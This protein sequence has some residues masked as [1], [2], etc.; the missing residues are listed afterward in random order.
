MPRLRGLLN[1]FINR[2]TRE[3]ARH[4]RAL[5]DL[6]YLSKLIED[7]FARYRLQKD[8]SS[9]KTVFENMGQIRLDT[10]DLAYQ[11]ELRIKRAT[12]IQGKDL[13]PIVEEVYNKLEEL[14][15][16]LFTRILTDKLLGEPVSKLEK[17]FSN[18][19]AAISDMQY[20]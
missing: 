3:N 9:F 18:L 14:K 4:N 17:A 5:R 10:I 12:N 2:V 7:F 20:K 8:G 13:S 11:T 1:V 16:L 15:R 6:L 19:L